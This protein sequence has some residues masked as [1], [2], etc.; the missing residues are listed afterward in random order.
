METRHLLEIKE[1]LNMIKHMTHKQAYLVKLYREAYIQKFFPRE[2]ELRK[3]GGIKYRKRR[4]GIL[5][6][7]RMHVNSMEAA[8][9]DVSSGTN[10]AIKGGSAGCKPACP[11][12]IRYLR[13]LILI[14]DSIENSL[15]NPLENL[16]VV[17]Q[18]L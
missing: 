11:G 15:Q 18:S 16:P 2:N 1:S 10:S 13:A 9:Q 12:K 6:K 5:A 8:P 4:R 17:I 7:R 3:P 14:G